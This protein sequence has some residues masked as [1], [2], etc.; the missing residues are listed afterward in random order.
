V[1][2]KAKNACNLLW[3]LSELKRSEPDL[4]QKIEKSLK[5]RPDLV[6]A[7]MAIRVFTAYSKNIAPNFDVLDAISYEL[8]GK[9]EKFTFREL[10]NL[11]HL[12][13]K[14]SYLN[15]NIL[16]GINHQMTVRLKA[17]LD[18]SDQDVGDQALP[19]PLADEEDE[20]DEKELKTQTSDNK[21]DEGS[22]SEE[23]SEDD[24]DLEKG[25][26]E[27]EPKANAVPASEKQELL[28]KE[29]VKAIA[30]LNH[31]DIAQLL[32]SM[33]R[34]RLLE[35]TL[36]RILETLFMDVLT[37]ATPASIA[38]VA[39]A[40]SMFCKEI[41]DEYAKNKKVLLKRSVENV[42]GFNDSFYYLMIPAI[43]NKLP[44][45]KAMELISFFVS[46]NKPGI[47]KRE[48]RRMMIDLAMTA[49]PK[50]K[51]QR[52]LLSEKEYDIMIYDFIR[53]VEQF[54]TKP[55]QKQELLV[56]FKENGIDGDTITK[57][58]SYSLPLIQRDRSPEDIQV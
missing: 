31:Q 13:A 52:A 55:I 30:E 32:S 19:E 41:M 9:L 7:E 3:C 21:K 18:I 44:E 38:A 37:T 46:A 5:A 51:E 47:K 11:L 36:F 56:K 54:V 14:L 23:E 57:N 2:I 39:F 29:T 48:L 53:C 28:K 1:E 20:S 10:A 33:A 43:K 16:N 50:L 45:S 15:Q 58:Y 24:S 26:S 25:E 49:L 4:V 22:S 6:D 34:L 17:A 8:L 42:K 35:P 40:H 12:C 27:G